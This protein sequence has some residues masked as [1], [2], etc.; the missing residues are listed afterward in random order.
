M[1]AVARQACK[2]AGM[3]ILGLGYLPSM[4]FLENAVKVKPG[5]VCHSIELYAENFSH[6]D[7]VKL[8]EES[9]CISDEALKDQ[10]SVI[11]ERQLGCDFARSS[12]FENYM[13]TVSP[14]NQLLDNIVQLHCQAIQSI[15]EKV[16]DEKP[17]VVA[18]K[19]DCLRGNVAKVV[20]SGKFANS[21]VVKGVVTSNFYVDAMR[22]GIPAKVVDS[23]I[24][25]L[26]S[27]V[28][29]RRSL[30]KGNEFEVMFDK[31]KRLVYCSISAGKNNKLKASVY[32][33]NEKGKIVYYREDGTKVAQPTNQYFGRPLATPMIV[34]SPYGMR[35]HPV[36]HTKRYH[37]GVDLRAHYGSPV[38]AIFDGVI[39]RA[40][41]YAGY[42][43]CIEIAHA[44]GYKSLYGHL[45][46]CS[47][48]CGARVKKGQLIGYSGSTGVST[49]PHLHLELARY[50]KLLNP[51]S[52]KMMPNDGGKIKD[53][54]VFN[55]YKGQIQSVVKKM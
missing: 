10:V 45:S 17:F 20:S 46:R 3:L 54:R 35:V 41:R 31:Q 7:S 22:L 1:E 42:G 34:S 23:M 25:N 26:S 48:R 50:N 8:N 15:P 30:K 37:T 33:M 19:R 32:G 6:F 38:Y 21:T 14:R 36:T 53:L 12:F 40:S 5:C 44:S 24:K 55:S 2:V 52:V 11:F 49:G 39:V 4:Q 29:F 43:N 47:V 51:M 27:K 28:N 18:K 9:N 16:F 13:P